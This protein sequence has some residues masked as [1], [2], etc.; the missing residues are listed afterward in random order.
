MTM[1]RFCAV[2]Y[3]AIAGLFLTFP[4]LADESMDRV[5]CKKMQDYYAST[6]SRSDNNKDEYPYDIKQLINAAQC[7]KQAGNS[8]LSIEQYKFILGITETDPYPWS[9][10]IYLQI[11]QVVNTL[12]SIIRHAP[13]RNDEERALVSQ[14]MALIEAYGRN[15]SSDDEPASILNLATSIINDSSKDLWNQI[16]EDLTWYA[17]AQ[18][19]GTETEI[20]RYLS[21]PD[22]FNAITRRANRYLGYIIS[23][24][25]N[26]DLPIEIALIPIIESSLNSRAISP[27]GAAGLWQIMPAT[28]KQYRLTKT[29]WYDERFDIRTSTKLALRHLETLNKRFDGNW[30]VTLS[31]YNSGL[32]RMRK[33]ISKNTINENNWLDLIP[34]ET[35]QYLARVFALSSI[36]ANPEKFGVELPRI[37]PS[38][39]FVAVRTGGRIELPL[40]AQ[41]AGMEL[42]ALRDFNPGYLRWATPKRGY[43]ELL[44]PPNN[45]NIFEDNLSDLPKERRMAGET[46]KVAYG[47]SVG[48][49]ADKLEVKLSSLRAINN[50]RRNMILAGETLLIPGTSYQ[51]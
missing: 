48:I 33:I 26:R 51:P 12:K 13:P 42:S 49:I 9:E 34:K 37:S 30:L 19:P 39:G 15:E 16:R 1:I 46:Y 32:T 24:I 10:L 36:V 2:H 17:K 14:M 7:S 40:A 29:R 8:L 25:T 11:E 45:A 20:E 5:N 50:I 43:Q 44:M 38:D 4:S 3:L 35:R 28:A 41:L 47:D 18:I 31:A 27:R 23:E 21:E 6:I 22:Y